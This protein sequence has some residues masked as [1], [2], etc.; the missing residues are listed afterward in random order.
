M[1]NGR[2]ISLFFGWF[3]YTG[4]LVCQRTHVQT[5]TLT[6]A[7]LDI[8]SN[9]RIYPCNVG[10]TVEVCVRV[11]VCRSVWQG[12]LSFPSLVAF[13]ES[14]EGQL[15]FCVSSVCFG[16]QE[17]RRGRAILVGMYVCKWEELESG[18]AFGG[19]NRRWGACEGVGV[20]DQGVRG[21]WGGAVSTGEEWWDGRKLGVIYKEFRKT[22]DKKYKKMC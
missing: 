20:G 14:P 5:H 8:S 4:V 15:P 16:A 21:R 10:E 1:H 17:S 22:I 9:W 2:F 6:H 19:K 13:L 18:G 7:R 3:L 11:G 12:R